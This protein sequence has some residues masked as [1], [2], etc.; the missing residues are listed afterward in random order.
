MKFESIIPILY[1]SDIEKSIHYYIDILGFEN[2]WKWNDPPTFGGINNGDVRLFFCKEGQ[3]Q[4][5]TWFAVNVDDVDAYYETIKAKGA[6]VIN[7]PQSF[8][9]G[10]R[11]MLIEDPDGHQIRFGQGVA[12]RDKSADQMPEMVRLAERVPTVSELHSLVSSV[13][14]LQPEE[15]APAEIPLTAIAYTVVAENRLNS[16]VIGCAFL[17]SD[18]AGFYYVKNVIVHP[19]WQGRRVGRALMQKLS[20]WLD[21]HAPDKAM[22][23]L[24]T[25]DYLA[26]FYRHFGFTP[27]FSMQKRIKRPPANSSSEGR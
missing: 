9:W 17:L 15:E 11:E 27:A 1:S 19:A 3:G 13:G 14:W 2:S 18:N 23:A 10:M 6:K 20:Q 16:Q 25:G 22:V 24:H 5:G 21:L 12:I 26:P 7:P 8:E 4:R